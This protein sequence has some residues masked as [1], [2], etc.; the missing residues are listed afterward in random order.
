[1][2]KTGDSGAPASKKKRM[3]KEEN[4]KLAISSRIMKMRAHVIQ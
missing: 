1:M 4:R 2:H 3:R